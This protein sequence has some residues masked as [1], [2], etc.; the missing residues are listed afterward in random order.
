M[1]KPDMVAGGNKSA[2][3]TLIEILIVMVIISIVGAASLLSI[4]RNKNSQMENFARQLTNLITLAQQQAMLQPAVIGMTFSDSTVQFYQYQEAS[5]K[6]PEAWIALQSSAL[7][8]HPIPKSL[9]LVLK[10]QDKTIVAKAD[11]PQLIISTNGDLTPFSIF[12]GEKEEAARYRV[13]GSDDG[14][15]SSE[16]IPDEK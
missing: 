10:M 14:A 11:Q 6:Q 9:R 4:S 3:F 1:T 16:K 7:G 8:K 5:A 15:V 13:I 2:G 12:I